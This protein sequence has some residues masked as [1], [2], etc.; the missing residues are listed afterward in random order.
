MRIM[1]VH[2]GAS[3]STCDVYDGLV[4]GLRANGITPI[5]GRLD[6]ILSWYGQLI[7]GGVEQGV[8]ARETFLLD[9]RLNRSALASAHITRAALLHAPEWLIVV[10]GH[11]YNAHDAKALRRAGIRTAL[12]CTES[13]YWADV[14]P[15]MAA[16]YDVVFTNERSAVAQFTQNERV[17]YLPHA[18]NPALHSP[19]LP[20][21]PSTDVFFC[22]SLF[23]ERRALFDAVDWAGIAFTKR[24]YHLDTGIPDLL[25]NSEVARAYRGA[26]IN[27][28]HHR[29]TTMHGSGGHITRAESLGPRA[30]EIAACGGF[31]L[32]DDSR[33]EYRDIFGDWGATYRAG[34]SAGLERQV[35]YWLKHDQRR[36]ETAKAMYHAVQPHSWTARAAQVLGVLCG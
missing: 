33:A 11:N 29:T 15:Q 13:P 6:T 18:Y 21:G 22:G 9:G 17:H 34:D 1:V 8:L 5:E 19:E 7:A 28:N 36:D 10:S 4:V 16:F 14:E 31:Q 20:P 12:I 30:Y 25:P 35:R 23:D 26:K 3:F 2:P 24:G 32:C 27:L